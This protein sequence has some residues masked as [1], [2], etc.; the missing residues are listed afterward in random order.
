MVGGGGGE[1]GGIRRS[2]SAS[3]TDR[4]L[5]GP[6]SVIGG[7]I[8]SPGVLTHHLHTAN[9]PIRTRALQSTELRFA[10]AS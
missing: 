9:P 6:A 1:E 3:A 8:L 10:S 4:E 2:S 7:S 5:S